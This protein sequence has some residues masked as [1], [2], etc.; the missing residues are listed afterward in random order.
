MWWKERINSPKLFLTHGH[1]THITPM[2]IHSK[3]PCFTYFVSENAYLILVLKSN[4]TGIGK[5]AQR[6]KYLSHKYEDVSSDPRAHIGAGWVW[7]LAC[8]S[9]AQGGRDEGSLKKQTS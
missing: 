3:I 2:H 4:T 1:I 6:I 8:M 7:E 5:M 9:S